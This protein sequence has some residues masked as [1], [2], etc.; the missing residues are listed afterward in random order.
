MAAQLRTTIAAGCRLPAASY[1][2]IPLIAAKQR[3]GG[4]VYGVALVVIHVG[5]VVV[6]C[7]RV[8]FKQ[9]D[10]SKRGESYEEPPKKHTQIPCSAPALV[11]RGPPL[12]D[13]SPH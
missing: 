12:F 7:Y 9:L 3:L 8:Q 4:L 13:V 11:Q 1:A 10:P 2:L 5:V 6:Y